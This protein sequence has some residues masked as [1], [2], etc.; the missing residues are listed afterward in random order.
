MT[1][2]YCDLDIL[3]SIFLL[4]FFYQFGVSNRTDHK[5]VPFYLLH[6]YIASNIRSRTNRLYIGLKAPNVNSI[7]GV[8]S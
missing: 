1:M 4:L 3:I 2:T 8:H 7:E 5:I 6:R